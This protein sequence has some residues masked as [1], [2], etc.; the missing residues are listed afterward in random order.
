MLAFFLYPKVQAKAQAELNAVISHGTHLLNFE[1]HPQLLYIDAIVLEAM[2]WNSVVSLGIAHYT[3]KEDVYRDYYIP[4][5]VTIIGNTWAMLHDEK[6]YL[7]PLVFD[8]NQFISQERKECEPEPTVAFGFERCI[9][10]DH[11]IALDTAWIAITSI[12]STLSFMKAID[13]EG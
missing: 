3:M 13:S 5:G 9:C 6:D 7:N 10:P 12:V 4:A 8:P 11:Y 2:R 1:D